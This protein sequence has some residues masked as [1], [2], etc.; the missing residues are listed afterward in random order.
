M[1]KRIVALMI[2]TAESEAE[3]FEILNDEG[4]SIEECEEI[5]ILESL[6]KKAYFLPQEVLDLVKN[7]LNEIKQLG[8]E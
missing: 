4:I 1:G 5:S 8:K 2:E 7:L 3:I 6:V